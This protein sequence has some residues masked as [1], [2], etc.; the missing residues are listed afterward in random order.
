L[1]PGA[2]QAEQRRIVAEVDRQLSILRGVEAEV[3]ANLQRT[4]VLRQST[5]S[6]AFAQ[7]RLM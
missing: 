2:I 3:N 1:I 6:K 4:Q 7:S 5:L